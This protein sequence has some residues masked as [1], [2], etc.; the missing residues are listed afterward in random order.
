MKQQVPRNE[1]FQGHKKEHPLRWVVSKEKVF[2]SHS[3]Q[4]WKC[5]VGDNLSLLT[6]YQISWTK[7]Q[8]LRFL[9]S[10]FFNNSSVFLSSACP[11]F[12]SQ[13]P[14]TRVARKP[15]RST[16]ELPHEARDAHLGSG[17]HRVLQN[18]PRRSRGLLGELR[19]VHRIEKLR[20]RTAIGPTS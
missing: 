4:G 13:T 18:A 15:I 7:C 12:W 11:A 10:I 2:S 17:P 16:E 5:V 14:G 1:F 20:T 9:T 8:W 3:L 6:R 19:I